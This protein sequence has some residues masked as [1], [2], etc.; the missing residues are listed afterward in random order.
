LLNGKVLD[1]RLNVDKRNGTIHISYLP[2]VSV[3]KW[4]LAE[5]FPFVM[6]F[7]FIG[8]KSFL[9]SSYLFTTLGSEL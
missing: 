4:C 1:C 8:I 9:I 5:M 3:G 7:I 2:S 6:T